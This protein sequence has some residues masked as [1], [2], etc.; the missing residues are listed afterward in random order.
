MR[1]QH[2]RRCRAFGVDRNAQIRGPCWTVGSQIATAHA[3]AIGA[4]GR[5]RKRCKVIRARPTKIHMRKLALLLLSVS[6]A[7]PLLAQPK[8]LLNLDKTGIAIQGYDPV[9]FFTDHKPVKGKGEFA[10]KR[11]GAT[12]LFSSQE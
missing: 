8:T 1:A 6:L 12:Y 10:T 11:D 4:G 5:N 9:A 3:V 2:S 7:T